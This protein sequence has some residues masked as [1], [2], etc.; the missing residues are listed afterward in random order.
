M[1]QGAAFMS[2]GQ[3]IDNGRPKHFDK[4]GYVRRDLEEEIWEYIDSPEIL[5]VVGPR[6]AG[7]TT[8]FYKINSE[9][10]NSHFISFEDRDALN[11]FEEDEKEFAEMHLLGYDYLLIDE[12]QYAERGGKKLKYLYDAYPDKKIMIT[13]SSTADMTVKGLKYLTGRVLKFQLFPFNFSEFLRYKDKKLYGIYTEK[14]ERIKDWLKTG[15]DPSISDTILKK[16]E[17]LRKEYTIYGGYPRVVLSDTDKKKRKILENV[18]D[19]YLIREIRDVL[20]I[21]KDRALMNLMKILALQIGEKTNYNSVCEKG[22][23]TYN[24]LK[25]WLNVLEHT[26]VLKQVRPFYTNKKKEVVKAPKLYFYDNGFRNSIIKSFGGLELRQD[27]GELNENF[28]FTQSQEELKYWRTKSKAEVDFILDVDMN[29][30]GPYPFEIKTTPKVTRSF[31]SFQ[32]KYSPKRSF[33]M[34]EKELRMDGGTYF[35][36][37]VFSGELVEE[38]G[39]V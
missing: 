22:E 15:E 33:I 23:I 32:K 19:T 2:K 34:N 16:L 37:L 11:L 13:G 35:V 38:V 29:E 5:A 20:G 6:Q 28:F 14:V 31:R 8:L 7:K 1:Y 18:V 10:D 25:K 4:T 30:G 27:K 26:F 17:K 36:P 39:R 3:S 21:S 24:D 9:L 12:F